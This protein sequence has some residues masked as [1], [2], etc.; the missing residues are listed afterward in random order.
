MPGRGQI[1]VAANG[2]LASFLH[3]V[4]TE[5]GQRADAA[6]VFGVQ[7]EETP[8]RF[9][10]N[11][12]KEVQ[13]KQSILVSLR[14]VKS[15]RT[16]L[17][18]TS[19]LLDPRALVDMALETTPFGTEAKFDFPGPQQ[20]P[21]VPA[22]DAAVQKRSL[23][24]MA[25]LGEQAISLVRRQCPDLLCDA[26]VASS[27]AT[28]YVM[29][30]AGVDSSYTKSIS[31]L[32]LEGTLIQGEDMLFVGDF[33]V[34]CEPITDPHSVVETTQWQLDMARGQASVST[35]TMPVVFTPRAVA[36]AL[37][38]PLATGFNG[39]TVLEGA[40]PLR[41][42][43][44]QK[45]FDARVTLRDD[46]L[47]PF[48]PESRPFDDEAVASQQ[49]VMAEAGVVRSFLYDLHT[50]ALAGARSTGNANRSRGGLPSPGTT[51]LAF[52]PGE[53][54]FNDMVSE[55][56]EGLVVDQLIGAEQGNILG[57]DFSGNV[58]L[59]FKIERG[60]MVGRVKNVMVSGNVY[61]ALSDVVALG[62]ESRRVYGG[63]VRAPHI[64]VR[65]LSVS[66]RS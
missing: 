10:A 7:S 63:A 37:S 44:G 60:R 62:R 1:S 29:N 55:I 42:R 65:G 58:L 19:G 22:F 38:S 16:G 66:A 32:S 45:V 15:G 18:T 39:K 53:V 64:W 49:T 51:C 21:Q 57:G 6:E 3:E 34:S 52:E 17:A 4:M 9:E 5:A 11:R 31:A 26:S 56:K 2:S 13:G 43:L 33:D 12:L 47:T 36:G 8:V 28:V 40:S 14:L 46:P 61:Q 24:D 50:A 23:R 25:D 20:Y 35:G 41:D 30:S 54:S 27:T 59:G 48:M